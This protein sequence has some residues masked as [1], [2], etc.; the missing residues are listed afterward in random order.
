M[1]AVDGAL[2]SRIS[3][4][5]ARDCGLH[6]PGVAPY[7]DGDAST[8]HHLRP[9]Q[10]APGS[11]TRPSV[12]EIVAV[13]VGN[14]SFRTS[15]T[16][17]LE[18]PSAVGS[19]PTSL[20]SREP[21]DHSRADSVTARCRDPFPSARVTRKLPATGPCSQQ[22]RTDRHMQREV[23]VPAG[24]CEIGLVGADEL[25]PTGDRSGGPRRG[26]ALFDQGPFNLRA[27]GHERR[28]K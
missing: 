3:F 4:M 14:R 18:R 22:V 20:L 16:Q 2:P 9:R 28:G 26:A 11:G 15:L 8:E 6:R 17:Q 10:N 7:P 5:N 27:A 1:S 19:H 24:G 12:S 23:A 25:D 13:A 21:A